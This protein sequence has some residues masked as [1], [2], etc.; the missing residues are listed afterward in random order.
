MENQS[1]ISRHTLFGNKLAELIEESQSLKYLEYN[2]LPV[3]L[4][5][6][7]CPI[8]KISF[9]ETPS[10]QIL[11][12]SCDHYFHTNCL[13]GWFLHRK[14][15]CPCCRNPILGDSDDL[16]KLMDTF[17]DDYFEQEADDSNN[18]PDYNIEDDTYNRVQNS[19]R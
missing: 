10:A 2:A 17:G 5:T 18:D 12:A 4:Q 15:S 19:R 1:T 7:L 3:E 14:S 16:F 13:E 6:T 9:H 8:C 11:V